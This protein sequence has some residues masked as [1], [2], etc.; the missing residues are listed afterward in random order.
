MT[1]KSK[2]KLVEFKSSKGRTY[3]VPEKY[4][5]SPTVSAVIRSLLD[6]GWDRKTIANTCNIRYQHVRNVELSP[7]KTQ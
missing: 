7:L 5:D 3:Q 6:D 4:K 1:D 2:L